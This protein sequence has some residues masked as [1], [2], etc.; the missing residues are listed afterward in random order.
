MLT[1]RLTVCHLLRGFE[2]YNM[3]SY[4]SKRCGCS[5]LVELLVVVQKQQKYVE[6]EALAASRWSSNHKGGTL[7][8]S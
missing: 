2:I 6:G 8:R 7:A 1:Q 5:N 4:H 3:G